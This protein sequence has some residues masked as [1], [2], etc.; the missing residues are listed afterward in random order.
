MDEITASSALFDNA[1]TRPSTSPQ[2]AVHSSVHQT[3]CSYTVV[4]LGLLGRRVDSRPSSVNWHGVK[5]NQV[6]GSGK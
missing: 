1:G 6:T 4:P 5:L 2:H 3:V